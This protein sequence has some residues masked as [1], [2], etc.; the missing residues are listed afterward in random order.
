[1]QNSLF[2][3]QETA[4]SMRSKGREC[5]VLLTEKVGPEGGVPVQEDRDRATEAESTYRTQPLACQVRGKPREIDRFA[6]TEGEVA[7]RRREVTTAMGHLSM[8]TSQVTEACQSIAAASVAREASAEACRRVPKMNSYWLKDEKDEGT[9]G[10][11]RPGRMA[12]TSPA[13]E[14][15]RDRQ[16]GATQDASAPLATKGAQAG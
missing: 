3:R 8:P 1:M 2:A 5:Q 6:P 7:R 16:V 13:G 14:G 12:A 15:T 10:R 11:E 9:R 4:R